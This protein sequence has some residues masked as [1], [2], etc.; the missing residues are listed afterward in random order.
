[1]ARTNAF[2][3][4]FGALA[5]VLARFVP[6]VRTFA[7]VAAGVGHMNYRK[8][9]L[10][11][12]VGAILWGIGVTLGGYLLGYIPNRRLRQGVHRHHPAR[13]RG[14]HPDP[15]V[16]HYVRSSMKAREAARNGVG[17]LSDGET[18]LKPEVFE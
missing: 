1:M 7:P 11:N 8:Y 2:F 12:F 3:V 17:P 6:I 15:T 18:T 10:Y 9:S 4:R 16:Y 5:V 14:R 13:R